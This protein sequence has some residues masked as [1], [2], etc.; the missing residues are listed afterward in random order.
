MKKII[1]VIIIFLLTGCYSNPS[2]E[3]NRYLNKYKS[4][5]KDVISQIDSLID[6]SGLSNDIKLLYKKAYEKQYSEMT[7]TILDYKCNSNTCD[8]PVK[9][10][11]YNY[12][13]VQ[14][15]SLEYLINNEDEFINKDGDYDVNLYEEYKLN[16]ILNTKDRITYNIVFNLDKKLTGWEIKSLNNIDLL[17]IHGLYE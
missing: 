16:Q 13:D 1:I 17:K 11:V 6:N 2:G 12:N 7:F 15:K 4:L 14:N 5:D 3:V 8:I 9:L 10:E